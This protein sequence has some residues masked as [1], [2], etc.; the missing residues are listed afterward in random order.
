MPAGFVDDTGR[1]RVQ[2]GP[3]IMLSGKLWQ[4]R[5][6]L[7]K[8]WVRVSAFALLALIS[9]ILAQLVAPLLPRFPGVQTGAEAVEQLLVV[10]ATSMLAVTTFSLSVAVQAFAAAAQ[11]AT[12]RATAL[13]Q[14]DPTTQN[15]LATFLG[16]FVFSLLGL[17]ALQADLYDARGRLILFAVTAGVVALV[18]VS[19]IRWI[20]HL[21]EFGRMENILDRVEDATT[22]A[23]DRR[24]HSP[25]LG[26][27]PLLTAPPVDG[28]K[29]IAKAAGYVLHLDMQRL[30]TVAGEMGANLYLSRLP[31]SYVAPGAPLIVVEGRAPD[32]AQ[33]HEMRAAFS[34]GRQRVFDDDPR[35]GLIVL[36]EIASRA[37][38]PAVNDPGTAIGVIGRLVRILSRWEPKELEETAFPRVHVPPILPEE[39]IIDAFRPI[40]RDG[41][42]MIEVHLRL[43]KALGLLAHTAPEVFG[44]A[45]SAMAQYDLDCTRRADLPESERA[46][47]SSLGPT[48]PRSPRVRANAFI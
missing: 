38:S 42:G 29:V 47:L 15:V 18:I 25:F 35:F 45:A 3:F 30:Q 44:P 40:A 4:L 23:L 11:T 37:L 32:D 2:I 27:R 10:L 39:A 5:L 36:S 16:A 9:A 20:S 31:G 8:I 33:V 21:M 13:L 19:L 17:V 34:F 7:R 24:L 22:A 46:Q 14:E 26:G 6:I 1:T 48:E 43:Q 28:H 41:A 12:P